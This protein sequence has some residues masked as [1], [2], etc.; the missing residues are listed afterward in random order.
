M[1]IQSTYNA[2]RLGFVANEAYIKISSFYYDEGKIII[3]TNAYYNEIARSS[4]L[5]PIGENTF[6]FVIDKTQPYSFADLYGFI[7]S[8][9]FP[10]GIDV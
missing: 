7:K 3:N 1:A 5:D 8:S 6:V 9:A 4:N 10:T 2:A